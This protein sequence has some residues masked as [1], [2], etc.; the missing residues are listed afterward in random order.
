MATAGCLTLEIADLDVKPVQT[1]RYVAEKNS[2]AVGIHPFVDSTESD[3]YFGT[4]LLDSNVLAVLVVVEN[5]SSSSSYILTKD[6]CSLST[7]RNQTPAGASGAPGASERLDAGTG[8]AMAGAVLV[9]PVLLIAG[10]KL[11]SDSEMIRHNF[12]RLELRRQTI[13]PGRTAHGVVY[14]ELTDD[15]LKKPSPSLVM[16]VS[17][18]DLKTGAV[19]TIPVRFELTAQ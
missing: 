8:L 1:Y 13:S 11:G 3:K 10:L 14:F 7:V 6:Q 5:R 12:H 17:L 9:S 15:Q 19:E 4:T 16:Q 18:Q 2:I